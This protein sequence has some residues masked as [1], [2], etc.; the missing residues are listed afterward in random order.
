MMPLKL[1]KEIRLSYDWLLNAQDI[2]QNVLQHTW[3]GGGHNEKPGSIV[4]AQVLNQAK[5]NSKPAWV[6]GMYF[7]ENEGCLRIVREHSLKAF[8]LVHRLEHLVRAEH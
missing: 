7:I 8:D 1:F 6:V 3:K 4:F 2:R 5:N